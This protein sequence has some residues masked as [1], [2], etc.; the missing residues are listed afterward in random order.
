MRR[1][2]K[3]GIRRLKVVP[4]GDFRAV[5]H[6]GTNNVPRESGLK[7]G[8]PARSHVVPEPRPDRQTCMADRS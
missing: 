7:V 5:A 8:L 6:P 2:F 3:V 1:F 4:F